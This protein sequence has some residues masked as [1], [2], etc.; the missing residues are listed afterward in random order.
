MDMDWEIPQMR[1][2]TVWSFCCVVKPPF[3]CQISTVSAAHWLTPTQ[4]FLSQTQAC[5]VSIWIVLRSMTTNFGHQTVSHCTLGSARWSIIEWW[6]SCAPY[7]KQVL[8]VLN[9]WSR[10][11]RCVR[12][13]KEGLLKVLAIV[14]IVGRQC[15]YICGLGGGFF[16]LAISSWLLLS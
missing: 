2:H 11:M 7:T 12:R 14:S 16:D 1:C 4:A 8:G 3:S 6:I 9:I 10:V 15:D 13:G 5:R